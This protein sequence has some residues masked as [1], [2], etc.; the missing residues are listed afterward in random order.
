MNIT[1]KV[2][3]SIV[4][5]R[6]ATEL[7]S[8]ET[9]IE[10]PLELSLKDISGAFKYEVVGGKIVERDFTQDE[11][12]L[13]YILENQTLPELD[14][15]LNQGYRTFGKGGVIPDAKERFK[16]LFD[17]NGKMSYNNEF[18]NLS[19]FNPELNSNFKYC[20]KELSKFNDQ[21]II[22]VDD[23]NEDAEII[24]NTGVS[25]NKIV[26][27]SISMVMEAGYEFEDIE[28]SF[29][30]GSNETP[31][32]PFGYAPFS[33]FGYADLNGQSGYIKIHFKLKAGNAIKKA[34]F[35]N[36]VMITEV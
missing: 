17:M 12:Y 13:D 15:F 24:I 11:I 4:I 16:S 35:D 5:E 22:F 27:A 25:A 19:D 6:Y 18:H 28:I 3:N 32:T 9:L 21:G 23:I 1:Y 29:K 2:K 31:I 7:Q 14:E 34:V 10:H 20:G 33:V 36:L 30:R 8:G 26:L